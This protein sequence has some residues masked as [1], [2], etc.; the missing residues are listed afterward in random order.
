MDNLSFAEEADRITDF[1]IFNKTQNIIIRS[2]GFL[3]RSH[4]LM[5]IR[6]WITF[7][8][9]SCSTPRSAAGCLRPESESMIYIIFIKTR[10][11]K[12]FRSQITGEL[13]YNG[14]DNLKMGEFLRTWIVIDIAPFEKEICFKLK[15]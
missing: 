3:L 1:R 4:I 13:V 2:A 9:E 15:L 6:N 7:R 14:T 10:F 8:L 5:K 11:F 12:L